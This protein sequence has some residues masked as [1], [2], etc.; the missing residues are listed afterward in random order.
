LPEPECGA[1][2]AGVGL[3]APF[4]VTIVMPRTYRVAVI[5]RTG[6]GNYGHG[7]DVVWKA[8]DNVQIVAVADED[9]KGRAAAATRLGAKNAYADYREML[10]KEKPQI[11]SVA[12]RFLDLHRDMIIACARAGASIFL[13]KPMARTLE[14]ADAMV[15]ACETHHVR[16]AIAFQT[17]Y[18]PRAERVKELI[19]DGKLGEILELRSRGKE[20]QR[21]G[22]Q[23]LMVLGTHLFDLMRYFAG[24]ARWCFASISQG[25][26]P[27][28]KADVKEGGENMGPVLGDSLYASYGFDG[29]IVGTFGSCRAKDGVSAR[30]GL[31]VY[32]AKGVV[33]MTTGSL[34]GTYFVEDPTWAPGRGKA[35]PQ[36]VTSA[37]LGKPETIKDGS[38]EQGN[39]WIVKDLMEAIEKDRQPRGSMYEGRA[40]LEMI[41]AVYESHRVKG[42]AELPLKNRKHPLTML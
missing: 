34:P 40:A 2:P 7:L 3:R 36:Q 12:D 25:G 13:E 22:G 26:K 6:K 4:K 1:A 8:F 14:E 32:G 16:L 24:D 17:R 37:G 15:T 31:S 42:P 33:H 29:A 9:E 20:D 5:G 18:S 21:G 38:L 23:D 39:V 19:A 27:A 30:F 11:V 35:T 10:D 28:T 41:L